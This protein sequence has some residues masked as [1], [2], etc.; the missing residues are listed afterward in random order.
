MRAGGR[1]TE[2]KRAADASVTRRPAE[3]SVPLRPA[4]G[5]I[6]AL[7][8]AIGNQAMLGLIRSA[9]AG[10]TG[11]S[12]VPS[13]LRAGTSTG[14][15]LRTAR[16]V[17]QRKCAC[18]KDDEPC[19][20]C[21][22]SRKLQRSTAAPGAAP[23]LGVPPI[24]EEVLASP[25]QQLD[26]SVR[27]F[28]EPKF[29]RSFEDVR[30]HTDA[31]A[32]ESARAVSANAYTVGAHIAFD[33]GHY[34]TGS[35]DGRR[36]IAHELTHVVQQAHG[37]HAPSQR[38]EIEAAS[39]ADRVTAG[40]PAP[41]TTG[42]RPG[43]QRQEKG[44]GEVDVAQVIAW[45][46]AHPKEVEAM[47]DAPFTNEYKAKYFVEETRKA[48]AARAANAASQ[49]RPASG[50]RQPV[51]EKEGRSIG[52]YR[53]PGPGSVTVD[54]EGVRV[55]VTE[56]QYDALTWRS[57][58]DRAW[59]MFNGLGGIAV[60]AGAGMKATNDRASGK[61]QSTGQPYRPPTT[62][63]GNPGRLN[64]PSGGK[65]GGTGGAAR[66]NDPK[67]FTPPGR[68]E[69]VGR[70]RSEGL[71][72]QAEWSGLKHVYSRDGGTIYLLEYNVN[73]VRFDSAK[74]DEWH[75]LEA[76]Q[77][78]KSSY[79]GSIR[80]GNV[81]VSNSLVDQATVQVREADRL[82]VKLEWHVMATQEQAFRQ[83][84]GPNLSGRISWQPYPDSSGGPPTGGQ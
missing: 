70:G 3:S 79:E 54:V 52:K 10:Q 11:A 49:S 46:T 44:Q 20:Q 42:A 53:E 4:G 48:N 80:S 23:G 67:V 28:M 61:S 84:L 35:A 18:E 36:L 6:N 8:G 25:G 43:L 75:N 40:L 60:A 74:F 7:R 15:P 56:E 1:Q 26:G 38:H 5:A 37:Q 13:L 66:V 24:V 22:A 12:S 82:G 51:P 69:V 62:D 16:G 77:E 63:S 32:A 19:E 33:S 59:E 81:N 50:N 65:S 2:R 83:V 57:R 14:M 64:P 73:G 21:A 41:V 27:S 34:A 58:Q 30:V 31:R 71:E 39:T 47:R 17:L 72:R 55:T 45:M 76:L 29:G 9:T 78:F 68:W